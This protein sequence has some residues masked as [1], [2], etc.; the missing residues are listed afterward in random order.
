MLTTI[1]FFSA[2]VL[3][4]SGNVAA[5]SV[6]AILPFFRSVSLET[7]PNLGSIGFSSSLAVTISSK[8]DF[9][10]VTISQVT[11]KFEFSSL[12]AILLLVLVAV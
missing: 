9:L 1:L 7:L 6:F 8:Y 3:G 12:S 4:Q 2:G 11:S 10:K 5:I